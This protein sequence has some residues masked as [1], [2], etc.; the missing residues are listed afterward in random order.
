MN[1]DRS[2]TSPTDQCLRRR[3]FPSNRFH[4]HHRINSCRR[5]HPSTE[6]LQS[7]Q[8]P[9]PENAVTGQWPPPRHYP[10][11]MPSS[12]PPPSGWSSP[13][14]KAL[15]LSPSGLCIEGPF[16]LSLRFV[17]VEGPFSLSPV[18]R[19]PSSKPSKPP[20]LSLLRLPPSKS[21]PL[22]PSSDLRLSLFLL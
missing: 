15:S 11:L 8:A 20:S 6:E 13:P 7:E 4:R 10:H 12:K 16:S 14:S 19:S 3:T 21:L 18:R 17:E 5:R 22:F 2:T 9:T 1:T